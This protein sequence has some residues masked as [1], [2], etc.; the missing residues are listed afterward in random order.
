M[1]SPRAMEKW[2]GHTRQHTPNTMV[3]LLQCTSQDHGMHSVMRQDVC[4]VSMHLAPCTSSKAGLTLSMGNSCL[5]GAGGNYYVRTP[6]LSGFDCST[7]Q[8]WWGGLEN[9]LYM[10]PAFV[11]RKPRQTHLQWK[12]ARVFF[13]FIMTSQLQQTTY[14]Y[15][16][17]LAWYQNMLK[18]VLWFGTATLVAQ[19]LIFLS[20]LHWSHYWEHTYVHVAICVIIWLR[21]VINFFINHCLNTPGCHSYQALRIGL[22][23]HPLQ[24][25]VVECTRTF[26]M[27]LEESS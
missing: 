26:Y 2:S 8:P 16:Q 23:V 13:L 15:N 14:I 18:I 19:S 6:L 21:L 4:I 11:W 3:K 25:P 20:K 12:V 22:M 9:W 27:K 17:Q 24:Q 5:E 10:H 7:L 1:M